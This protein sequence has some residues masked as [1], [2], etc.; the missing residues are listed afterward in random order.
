[1]SASARTSS[2]LAELDTRNSPGRSVKS[3]PA[4]PRQLSGRQARAF[5]HSPGHLQ[6]YAVSEHRPVREPSFPYNLHCDRVP[7]STASD[8][9]CDGGSLRSSGARWLG[10]QWCG[11]GSWRYRGREPPNPP[12]EN[13]H[14]F[15]DGRLPQLVWPRYLGR[16]E[17]PKRSMGQNIPTG[18]ANG[19]GSSLL[20]CRPTVPARPSQVG[21]RPNLGGLDNKRR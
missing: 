1:M 14:A 2:G 13:S 12:R 7:Q 10:P 4:S 11:P 15:R 8:R 21:T 17:A 20:N 5:S 18:G 19:W 9:E 6:T 16:S 3:S